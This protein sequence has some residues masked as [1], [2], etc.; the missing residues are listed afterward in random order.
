MD[1]Q[2]YGISEQPW[3]YEYVV[4]SLL[5]FSQ[6]KQGLRQYVVDDFPETL[7]H[8]NTA[9]WI[10]GCALETI[11]VIFTEILDAGRKV[12]EWFEDETTDVKELKR[13]FFEL[14]NLLIGKELNEILANWENTARLSQEILQQMTWDAVRVGPMRE[15]G[16]YLDEW[17]YGAYSEACGR[18]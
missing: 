17:S 12:D 10:S 13:Q 5:Y 18:V 9:D 4:N 7:F 14:Y 1:Q 8:G 2:I 6:S 15:C 3:P 11:T 16:E